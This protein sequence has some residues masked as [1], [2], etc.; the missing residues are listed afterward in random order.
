MI[1]SR[2]V[3]YKTKYAIK[4]KANMWT[5]PLVYKS[6][7]GKAR[8]LAVYDAALAHWPVPYERLDL[9]TRF[10]STHVIA[11]G[12]PEGNAPP[13]ILLH[14]NWETAMMWSSSVTQLCRDYRVY[15]LDQIDD[16]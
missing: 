15:A 4:L 10:G 1:G 7:E 16:G 12:P 2:E 11:N 13:V 9:S 6:L 3:N 5:D 14:R 8:C